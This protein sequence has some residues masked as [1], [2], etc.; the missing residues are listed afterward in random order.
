MKNHKGRH[1]SQDIFESR[2]N[3]FLHID[4][5]RALSVIWMIG[6]HSIYFLG[7]FISSKEYSSIL[8][9]QQPFRLLLDGLLGVDVFF[10][11]SG[12]LIAKILLNEINQQGAIQFRRFYIRR[13]FRIIP[14]YLASLFL[15]GYL[16]GDPIEKHVWANLLLINNYLPVHEQFMAWSWSLAVEGQFYLLFPILLQ[17]FSKVT[18][19]PAFLFFLLMAG[20]L[21]L[22]YFVIRDSGMQPLLAFSPFF[23]T[24]GFNR[25]FDHWYDKTHL[26]YGGILVGSLAAFLHSNSRFNKYFKDH[27]GS[28]TALLLLSGLYFIWSITSE[29]TCVFNYCTGTAPVAYRVLY[30]TL[31]HFMI[32]LITAALILYG[33]GP[34][35]RSMINKVLSSRIWRPFAE[36]SLSAYLLHPLIILVFYSS[37]VMAGFKLSGSLLPYGV[38]AVELLSFLAASMMY[39]LIE[40]P[41]REWGDRF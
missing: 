3:R 32:S 28:A 24:V 29:Q 40:E 20:S 33:A 25:W 27:K 34:G 30:E 11:I 18:R 21:L 22:R 8:A 1:L 35:S 41:F 4:G 17:I 13:F 5:L 6:F 39:I 12:F 38:I 2:E 19:R 26:R 9:Q 16:L 37:I 10:A 7:L 23:D 31:K 14:A 36:V 15:G